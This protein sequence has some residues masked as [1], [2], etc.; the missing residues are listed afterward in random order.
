MDAPSVRF[1]LVFARTRRPSYV[2]Q[3]AAKRENVSLLA[4]RFTVLTHTRVE[5]YGDPF[6]FRG[7]MRIS[8]A[9]SRVSGRTSDQYGTAVLGST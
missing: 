6:A 4:V 3:Q 9:E 8:H 1:Q 7:L 2:F 5:I